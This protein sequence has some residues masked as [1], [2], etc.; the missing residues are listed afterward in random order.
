M[1]PWDA[2]VRSSLDQPGIQIKEG[3]YI[4]AVN[5]VPLTTAHEPFDVFQD[6]S[7]KAVELTYNSTPSWK[8]AKNVIV[9]TMADEYRLRNLAWIEGNRKR[10]KKQLT[11]KSDIFM[12]LA[13]A[14]TGKMIL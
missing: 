1:L 4:L 14:L 3:D 8:G 5:G 10:V 11:E 2:E 9:Q 13:Q 6:L 12:C 7:N